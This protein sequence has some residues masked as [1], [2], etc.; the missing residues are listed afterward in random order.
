MRNAS[1]GLWPGWTRQ[2]GDVHSPAAMSPSCCSH[3]IQAPS[4]ISPSCS[5]MHMELS[6]L[7]FFIHFVTSKGCWL[8]S[9]VTLTALNQLM[10]MIMMQSYLTAMI[11]HR[12][13]Q[14]MLLDILIKML[15]K[16]RQPESSLDLRQHLSGS[17]DRRTCTVT[18]SPIYR[19]VSSDEFR[20][21][22]KGTAGSKII[23]CRLVMRLMAPENINSD[24]SL[25]VFSRA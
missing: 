1:L 14:V 17:T 23:S 9:S 25:R 6:S 22:G 7:I 18:S 8:Q 3:H 19:S 16:C 12:E 2:Q 15:H 21:D 24:G 10:T 13:K 11:N 20:E 5:S 4:K